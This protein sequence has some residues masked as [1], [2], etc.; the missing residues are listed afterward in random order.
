MKRPTLTIKDIRALETK[1]N[2]QFRGSD[3]AL[4]PLTVQQIIK[5][6]NTVS[7]GTKDLNVALSGHP[8]C[9]FV[10]G[11]IVEI[12]GPEQC[13]SEDTEVVYYIDDG[14]NYATKARKTTLK[15]L[16]RRF[17]NIELDKIQG[18]KR[19]IPNGPRVTFKISSMNELGGIFSNPI[20]DVVECGVK[21][22]YEVRTTSG[23]LLRSTRDHKYYVGNGEYLPMGELGVGDTIYIHD[24]T[25]FKKPKLSSQLS[26][27]EL[28]VAWHPRM[29]TRIISGKDYH[30]VRRMFIVFE[31]HT[32]LMSVSQYLEALKDSDLRKNLYF[33]PE[34]STLHHKDLN[35]R[36]DSLK[37][38]KLMR[39]SDHKSYHAK[40][41]HNNL[42]Y[43]VVPTKVGRITYKGEEPTYDVKCYHPHN[44]YIANGLVVHNSGKTTLCLHIVVAAQRVNLPVAF[45]DA[46]HALDP[47]YAQKVGVN[48]DLLSISQPDHGE[49]ALQ[50]AEK[51]LQSGYKVL[52]IDSVAALTPKAELDG[53]MGASHIGLQAR[54]MGQAMRKLTGLIR[55]QNA[56]VVFTNQIREKVGV[57]FGSPETTPGGRALKFY[58]SYR[59][60]VRSPRGGAIKA[61]KGNKSLDDNQVDTPDELGIISK[62]KVVKNKVYPP[63]RKAEANIIY[64]KGYDKYEDVV[65]VLKKQGV[66]KGTGGKN[67][68]RINLCGDAY[69]AKTLVD[70]M[71][72]SKKVRKAALRMVKELYS[73]AIEAEFE[74]VS[75]EEIPELPEEE[76]EIEI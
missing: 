70:G 38:L 40:L 49:H 66:F 34:A 68:G 28:A 4:Q 6:E 13:L 65:R 24:R 19:P 41:S 5:Q 32:N 37:N 64:G 58:A 72:S 10:V 20:A 54:L 12:Y 50:V 55:K 31:A 52:L 22:V 3:K 23:Q 43:Q 74:V 33:V 27:R 53:E 44:N 48:L 26:Y 73:D 1:V 14:S 76:Y 69:T 35:K 17:H 2:A 7:S 36:N 16:Y 8:D 62:F 9:G 56:L 75:E 51:A 39:S 47:G 59:I 25:R 11:R 61:G 57:M 30:S 46:E 15:H 21:D 63:Y 18:S 45:I 29:S 60:D 71:K 67:T 42:R